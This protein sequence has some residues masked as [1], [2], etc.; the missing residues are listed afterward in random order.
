MGTMIQRHQ[1]E[2][3]ATSAASASPTTPATCAA[4]TTCSPDAAGRRSA[5]IHAAYLEAGA[6]I[7]ETN[8][9]NADA[10][11]LA[12]YGLESIA[13]ELNVAAAHA[14]P[15]GRR[16]RRGGRPGRPR[17]VAGVARADQPRPRRSRRTSTTRARATSPSTSW[18]TPTTE[19]ARGPGRAAAPT[20][21]S[22][23]TIFDTL[24][25]KAAIF[26]IE[27]LFDE[28]G[29]RLPVMISGTITDASGRTLSGQTVE[30][31]LDTRCATP[32]AARSGSTARSAPSCCART[33]QELSRLADVLVSALS[34]TPACRTSSAGTTRRRRDD[35]AQLGE[36]ARA[37]LVNI[38]GGCCGTTP[39]HIAAIADAVA[40]VPAARDPEHRATRRRARRASSRSTIPT[41]GGARSSTSASAPTSPA[42]ALRAA[43]SRTA[44]TTAAV[45]VARAAGRE[46]RQIIDVNMD[47]AHA[48]LR[49]RR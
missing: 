20:S 18:P 21:C 8:T 48:R 25:A 16:R 41:P 32:A 26:A 47:E 22:I 44:T 4:T 14:R 2:R 35:A 40:G 46:R 30:R 28:L 5:S 1:L 6:D 49:A 19:A 12:D 38:V 7:I 10:I 3:G 45:E 13:R 33:S 39:E 42:R 11:A 15:R 17:Y 29:A 43:R 31:V 23:E 34:R 9:F 24:N 37:G 27:R 36:L